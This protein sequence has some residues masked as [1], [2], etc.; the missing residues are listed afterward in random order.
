MTK[1]KILV[2]LDSDD[3]ASVFDAVVAVDSGVDRLF[4]YASVEPTK[5][6]DLVFGAMYTRGPQDLKS[7]AIFIGGADVAAGERLLETVRGCFNGPFR[8]SIMF[9]ANGAN[10]TAAAA[11]RAASRHVKFAEARVAI[12]GATGPVGSRAARL[13]AA[14]GAKLRVASRSADRSRKLAESLLERYPH[15]SIEPTTIS[16]ARDLQATVDGCDALISAGA[17]GVELI[18]KNQWKAIDDLKLIVDLNAVPPVGVEGVEILDRAAEREGRVCYGAIGIGGD[19]M[20]LHKAIVK[21]LFDRNDQ[22]FDA[23]EIYAV[24]EEMGL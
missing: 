3:H 22:V 2:Q 14:R 8:V 7:T 24:A 6:R 5:A 17:A 23:E 15:A 11:V 20:K 19:K 18:S 10:T 9:D 16:T 12:L 21:K 13:L 1:P 4:Q